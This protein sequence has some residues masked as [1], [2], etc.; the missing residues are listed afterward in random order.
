MKE[1]GKSPIP[2]NFIDELFTH[3]G[4]LGRLKR[5]PKDV[6]EEDK[7][8]SAIGEKWRLKLYLPSYIVRKAV[9]DMA[10]FA[11]KVI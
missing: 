10:P 4:Q 7:T 8:Y 6:L 5:Y 11:L 2:K 3:V 1:Y 9:E